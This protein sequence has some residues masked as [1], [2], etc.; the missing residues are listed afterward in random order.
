MALQTEESKKTP[1]LPEKRYARLA[2]S[3]MPAWARMSCGPRVRV[4]EALERL[5]DRRQAAA[6]VDED[7]DAALGRQREDGREPLV[8]EQELLSARMELDPTR[9]EVE[10]AARLL[11]RALVERE[12]HERDEPAFRAGREL[13]RPVVAGLEARVPV[14]LVEAEHEG[15]RDAVAVHGAD[16]LLVAPDH[17]V[18][19]RAEVGV[20]V[21]DLEV[22]G[23][24]GAQTLVP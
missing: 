12:P 5:R 16:Q 19:V 24:I 18:D 13:E 14:G 9:P 2:R 22:G 8:V 20:G 21:E 11:D 7:R 6:G 10:A 3:A 15:P 23:E 1:R 17:P 4:D